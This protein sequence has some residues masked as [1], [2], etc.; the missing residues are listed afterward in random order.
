MSHLDEILQQLHLEKQAK[1]AAE[2]AASLLK[3]DLHFLQEQLR[4]IKKGEE[5]R[6]Q[7]R[8][9]EVRSIALFSMENPDP[10][11]RISLQGEILFQ[12]PAS[13]IIETIEYKQEH[14]NAEDFWK[15]LAQQIPPAAERFDTEIVA[16]DKIF[17]IVCRILKREGYINIY[18]KDV[19]KQKHA[20]EK[21]LKAERRWKFALEGSGDGIWEYNFKT[22]KIFYS[23]QYKAMLGYTDEEFANEPDTWITLVHPDDVAKV[24]YVDDDYRASITESH[25]MEYRIRCKDGSYKWVL[26]RGQVISRNEDG[27]PEIIIGTHTDITRR[28]ESEIIL[29]ETEQRW[30]LALEGSG[31]GV[32][33]YNHTTKE[34]YTSAICKRILNIN[35]ENINVRGWRS[36]IHPDDKLILRK[37]DR[38]YFSNSSNSHNVEYRILQPDGTY[39]WILDRG[40]VVSRSG[41]GTPIK[42]TGLITDISD[43]KKAE[44]E[45]KL[46]EEK[47][48]GII[49]NMNLGL[50]ETDKNDIVLYVNQSFC[51][52]SGYNYDELISK[53]LNAMIATGPSLEILEHQNNQR[54]LGNSDVFEVPVRN[55]RGEVKWW[56]ISSVPL[57]NNKREITGSLGIHLDITQQ[58]VLEHNLMDAKHLAEQSVRAKDVFLANMSHEIRTPMNAILGLSKQLQKT[59]LSA[60]QQSYLS[61][62]QGATNSLLVIINDILDLSKIEAGKMMIEYIGFD[63]LHLLNHALSI[64][65]YKTEEKGL[66]LIFKKDENVNHLFKG[67]PY[68]I[69]QVL[70]NLLSNAVKFTDNGSVTLACNVLDDEELFQTIQLSVTDTGIGMDEKFQQQLFTKFTQE[71][72]SITRKYGGSGLGMSITKQ[73][74]ELMEG[75]I[76]VKSKK[77]EGTTIKI[78]L[79]LEKTAFDD[80]PKKEEIIIENNNLKDARILLVEDND[81]NRLVATTILQQYGVVLDEAVNGS[82]A[83]NKIAKEQYDIVLMDVRMPVMDGL[84][85]TRIIRRNITTDLPIIAL[86]ANA[87]QGEA[88]KCI[89]AGMNDFIVKP[90]GEDELI[91]VIA[92]WLNKT[93]V[94]NKQN[95]TENKQPN[96]LYNIDKLKELSSSN[97]FIKKMLNLFL[98]HIPANISD[99]HEALN[100]GDYNKLKDIAHSIKPT[101]D[102][103]NIHSEKDVIRKI[104]SLATGADNKE[105]LYTLLQHFDKT[106]SKVIE[107]VKTDM[108]VL[109]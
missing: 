29:Y 101:I 33:E 71:D 108:L 1:E 106:L 40:M 66:Q 85:A 107:Q 90:Y 21:Q 16:D 102:N 95:K 73:L 69:N 56:L 75:Y 44:Q 87:L 49:E 78:I 8:I 103:M 79:H 22:D 68:R 25:S 91:K 82:I 54:R 30:K 84:E 23:L 46:S 35:D 88:D 89:A 38:A 100:T 12:N 34:F 76:E 9:E 72:E 14:F 20:E 13:Y 70:M 64:I 26:D 5:K 7:S 98:Q 58:K 43:R 52:M 4:D 36:S 99:M 63:L 27:S 97:A 37:I 6:F 17:S 45:L 65:S 86:T 80:L 15:F 92:K 105:E 47:Y 57:Y 67:D 42:F 50:I 96:E 48:R 10:I 53:H 19:T 2:Q 55:K 28:K 77:D 94:A 31:D 32:W 62:V 60:L 74:V 104:E 109:E 24:T 51:S 83:V 61:S 59:P 18:G 93:V 39:K 3:Q 11:I 81:M 41:N